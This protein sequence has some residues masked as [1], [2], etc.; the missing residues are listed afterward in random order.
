MVPWVGIHEVHKIS[1]AKH[2]TLGLSGGAG[3][4]NAVAQVIGRPR[5]AGVIFLFVCQQILHRIYAAAELLQEC[6]PLPEGIPIHNQR[7][8]TGI[9]QHVGDTVIRIFGV[10]GQERGTSLQD[11]LSGDIH[12]HTAGQHQSNNIAGQNSACDQA[13]CQTVGPGIEL[14]ITKFFICGDNGQMIRVL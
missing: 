11:A 9:L 8:R 4:I 6:S 2:H 13:V 14:R 5:N 1:L 10:D 7:R 3:G 12:P